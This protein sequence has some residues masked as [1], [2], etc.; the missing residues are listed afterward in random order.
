M[1]R[2]IIERVDRTLWT[3]DEIRSGIPTSSTQHHYS[4]SINP[5]ST[6]YP[7][8]FSSSSRYAPFDP[9]HIR[10]TSSPLFPATEARERIYKPTTTGG[11]SSGFGGAAATTNN[12]SVDEDFRRGGSARTSK[13]KAKM[14]KA[15]KDFLHADSS[16]HNGMSL[17]RFEKR[18]ETRQ[19]FRSNFG[20]FSKVHR[21]FASSGRVS[22]SAPSKVSQR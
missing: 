3:N 13:Y 16:S 20:T 12:A 8:P 17:L 7:H 21:G 6:S 10:N 22:R 18:K 19:I 9:Q 4:S 1:E 5:S 2:Q 14:E 15:R 11:A